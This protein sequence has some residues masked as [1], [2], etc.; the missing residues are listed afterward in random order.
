LKFVNRNPWLAWCD[1]QYLRYAFQD[2][3]VV[4]LSKSYSMTVHL[5]D[6]F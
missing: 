2:L 3:K 5:S 4:Y 1:D 6:A